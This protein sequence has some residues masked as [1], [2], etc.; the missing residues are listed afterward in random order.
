[1]QIGVW[2]ILDAANRGLAL[3]RIFFL[4]IVYSCFLRGNVASQALKG[5]AAL[6]VVAITRIDPPSSAENGADY[7]AR[8]CD[9]K[10]DPKSV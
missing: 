6:F 4:H 10:I 1:L 3:E 9:V 2:I 8:H 5:F 7:S